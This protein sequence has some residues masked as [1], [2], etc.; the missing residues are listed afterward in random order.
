MTANG[1]NT[2]EL[3]LADAERLVDRLR[4]ASARLPCTGAEFF[5]WAKARGLLLP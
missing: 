3:V 5:E 2:G 4:D 1:L